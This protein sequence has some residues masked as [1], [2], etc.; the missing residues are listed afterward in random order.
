[1][2]GQFGFIFGRFAL[3]LP[4]AEGVT[5]FVLEAAKLPN[6]IAKGRLFP[7]A[8]DP[9]GAGIKAGL[10]LRFKKRGARAGDH[11]VRAGKAR[12]GDCLSKIQHNIT[13][14]DHQPAPDNCI[15]SM[16]V[17]Q[18]KVDDDPVMGFHQLFVLKNIN[19]KWVCSN[20]IFRL[21]LYNFA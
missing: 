4:L 20:D 9:D 6:K 3:G 7:K 11:N 18:L 15:L 17:G 16:I 1:M 12:V 19:D 10:L 2:P 21:A 13:S 14:Q 5:S 8:A